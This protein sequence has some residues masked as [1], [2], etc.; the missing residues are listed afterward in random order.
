MSVEEIMDKWDVDTLKGNAEEFKRSIDGLTKAIETNNQKLVE[1]FLN[2]ELP[3]HYDMFILIAKT[4]A[5]NNDAK[6]C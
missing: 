3:I 2:K 4:V 6:G 1:F 5:L